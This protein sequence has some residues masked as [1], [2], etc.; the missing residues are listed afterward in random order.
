MTLFLTAKLD[1]GEIRSMT[2]FAGKSLNNATPST[3]FQVIGFSYRSQCRRHHH[4]GPCDDKSQK[5]AFGASDIIDEEKPT[6]SSKPMF[7][8]LW[9]HAQTLKDQANIVSSSVALSPTRTLR[10]LL[11][12]VPRSWVFNTKLPAPVA[13][14]AE[15]EHVKFT[16]FRIIYQLFDYLKSSRR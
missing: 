16:N 9:S 14:L 12:P 2:D 3:P 4:S 13:R 8:A 5:S 1:F 6:L 10:L 11:P 7:K 15:I